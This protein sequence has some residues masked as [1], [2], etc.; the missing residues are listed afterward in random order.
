MEP[1]GLTCR[2]AQAEEGVIVD[3][4]VPKRRGGVALDRREISEE[5]AGQIDQM[6]ALVDEFAAAGER[7]IG[8]PL[9]VVAFA[10]SMAVTRT[11]KHERPEGARF[12]ESSGFLE[13][14]MKTVV[15]AD[16]HAGAGFG[17]GGLDSAELSGVESAG[18][19]NEDVFAGFDG[20]ERN[21]RKRGVERGNDDG[22][23]GGIGENCRVIGGRRTTGDEL[24]EIGGAGRV[25][26]ASGAKGDAR[27]F[28]QGLSAFTADKAAA[29]YGKAAGTRCRGVGRGH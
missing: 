29:Y 18:F 20:G 23:D 22:V 3:L 16:A 12:K 7:G 5:P 27:D 9:A 11:Q 24:R 26:V 19:F 13:G 2:R 10:A 14:G 4:H 8:A 21:G 6:H 1:R 15:V 25:E 28:A 17:G